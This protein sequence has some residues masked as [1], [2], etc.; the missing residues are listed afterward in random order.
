MNTA[1]QQHQNRP[2][3]V[4]LSFYGRPTVSYSPAPGDSSRWLM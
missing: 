3:S 4:L 1:K 2:V